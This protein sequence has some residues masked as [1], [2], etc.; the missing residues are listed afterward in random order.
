MALF[1]PLKISH[2]KV[3]DWACLFLCARKENKTKEF[4]AKS[5]LGICLAMVE[6]VSSAVGDR[7]QAVCQVLS[8]PHEPKI[9]SF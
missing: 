7:E 8:R 9:Y 4:L 6:S 1:C 5:V 3:E 2:K